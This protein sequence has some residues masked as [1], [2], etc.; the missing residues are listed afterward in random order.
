[1]DEL[2]I[3]NRA[4]SQAEINN[5]Y[6]KGYL[7]YEYFKPTCHISSQETVDSECLNCNP[8]NGGGECQTA[9]VRTAF[10]P[11]LYKVFDVIK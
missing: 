11:F 3:Y 4:L 8:I 5:Q 9:R 6:N 2:K 1:M 10:R 7:Y